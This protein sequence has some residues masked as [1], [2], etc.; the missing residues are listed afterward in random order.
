MSLGWVV[1]L[2]LVALLTGIGLGVWGTMK[3]VAPKRSQEIIG[4]VKGLAE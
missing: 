4:K 2:V 3:W 1:I